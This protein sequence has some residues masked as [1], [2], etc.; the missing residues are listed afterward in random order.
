MK[1]H[2]NIKSRFCFLFHKL[3]PFLFLRKSVLKL[4]R[5]S[6]TTQ[7]STSGSRW[8]LENAGG[9][10][11]VSEMEQGE[12]GTRG[13]GGC[14]GWARNE[15][16]GPEKVGKTPAEEAR[17]PYGASALDV[18]GRL[19]LYVYTCVCSATQLYLTLCIPMD[20]SPS[21]S[22]VH[23]IPRQEYWSGLPFPSPGDLPNPGSNPCLL[24]LL[25]WQVSSLPLCHL[26]NPAELIK[27]VP[28]NANGSCVSHINRVSNMEG[29]KARMNFMVWLRMEAILL[30]C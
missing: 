18:Y 4:L 19:G 14:G 16:P 11:R 27:Q 28:I 1:Y 7:A 6:W 15:E 17:C 10:D 21:G 25:Q 9:W 2:K 5:W 29:K 24:H 26:G 22:S 30:V 13:S 3:F 20:C 8:G 12:E 23:E